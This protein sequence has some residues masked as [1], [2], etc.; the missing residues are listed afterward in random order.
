M[1]TDTR[2]GTPA[3]QI[4]PHRILL[5]DDNM[6]AADIAAM[7][8]KQ[9]GQDVMQVYDGRTALDVARDFGPDII[10]LDVNMPGLHGLQVARSIRALPGRVSGCRIIAYTGFGQPE[11][12]AA[13]QAAGFDDF[14]VKP[15]SIAQWAGIL[16]APGES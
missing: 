13:A 1:G 15:V 5:V 16:G 14:L 9:L 10:V 8:L 7:L 2:A 6:D 3:A 12:R 11:H 4:Q